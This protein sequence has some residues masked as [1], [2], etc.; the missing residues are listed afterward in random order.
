LL[1]E[2]IRINCDR[3]LDFGSF[4]EEFKKVFGFPDFY[5]RNMN[6]WIDCMRDLNSPETLMTSV[7]GRTE[8]PMVIELENFESFRIRCPDVC[9][10]FEECAAVIN[11]ESILFTLQKS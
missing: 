1:L 10:A 8:A 5:G 9:T 3:I 11:K 4:H 2:H 7:H 6:A